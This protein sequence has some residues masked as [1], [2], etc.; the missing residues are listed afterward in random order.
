MTYGVLLDS[1][2]SYLTDSPVRQAREAAWHRTATFVSQPQLQT[3]Q[4]RPVHVS[5][6]STSR[7]LSNI[8]HCNFVRSNTQ[9]RVIHGSSWSHG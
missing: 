8:T 3:S 1:T 7:L 6:N 9:V 5:N 4:K 2:S